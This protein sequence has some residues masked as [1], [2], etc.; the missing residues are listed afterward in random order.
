M[1]FVIKEMAA[2][3]TVQRNFEQSGGT[4]ETTLK[5]QL[6]TIDGLGAPWGGDAPGQAFW[7]AYQAA[8]Q[9]VAA[10]ASQIGAQVKVLAD[11]TSATIAAYRTT[12]SQNEQVAGT[13]TATPAV[14]T[15]TGNPVDTTVTV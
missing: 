12:E 1:T 14:Y 11:N 5:Q 9:K 2:I 15:T 10:N 13:A 4:A 3:E 7:Q 8:A 6:S